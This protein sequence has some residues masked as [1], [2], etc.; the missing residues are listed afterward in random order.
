M[1]ACW[2]QVVQTAENLWPMV[3]ECRLGFSR[4]AAARIRGFSSGQAL[5]LDLRDRGLPPFRVLRDWIY[6]V[7]LL[8]QDARGTPLGRWVADQNGNPATYYRFVRELTGLTWG[9]VKTLGVAWARAEGCRHWGPYIAL[10]PSLPPSLLTK[11]E[12]MTP[13]SHNTSSGN[14]RSLECVDW[15]GGA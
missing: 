5:D 9:Q 12:N 14:C 4:A 3:R 10:P 7:L 13:P 6:L 2:D 11:R 15:G 8:E 1:P